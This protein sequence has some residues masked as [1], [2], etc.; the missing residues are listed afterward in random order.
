M[1]C[2]TMSTRTPKDELRHHCTFTLINMNLR[3]FGIVML[4]EYFYYKIY[5]HL[6]NNEI[7]STCVQAIPTTTAERRDDQFVVTPSQ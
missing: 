1:S 7:F 5:K 4:F 2:H 3:T 6:F